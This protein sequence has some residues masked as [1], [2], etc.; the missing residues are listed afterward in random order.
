MNKRYLVSEQNILEINE[1]I[2]RILSKSF[3]L[4][5]NDGFSY[6]ITNTE[7]LTNKINIF[8]PKGCTAIEEDDFVSITD[9]EIVIVDNG[10]HHSKIVL[11][12]TDKK[13]IADLIQ[14]DIY[15]VVYFIE[16]LGYTEA[17]EALA[18]RI[19]TIIN[20][21]IP[22]VTFRRV[23]NNDQEETSE[24]EENRKDDTISAIKFGVDMSNNFKV[25]PNNPDDVYS[26]LYPTH[27]TKLKYLTEE[28]WKNIQLSAKKRIENVTDGVNKK[29]LYYW[30]NIV[31]GIIP[32]SLEVIND[33]FE[34]VADTSYSSEKEENRKDDAINTIEL[35]I[36]IK[37]KPNSLEDVYSLLYPDRQSKLEYLTEEEWKYLQDTAKDQIEN[38]SGPVCKKI[39]VHWYDIVNGEV[40]FGL[41]VINDNFDAVKPKAI[42]FE[43]EEGDKLIKDV[44]DNLAFVLSSLRSKL[45]LSLKHMG[46]W[47]KNDLLMKDTVE[48]YSKLLEN[49]SKLGGK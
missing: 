38:T 44:E 3:I 43:N 32:F 4:I 28:E 39:L 34:E 1:E 10:D 25:K 42:P 36:G 15:N 13:F 29:L 47:D 18:D 26:L 11:K 41:E 49:Y 23:K 8:G 20:P 14:V 12:H 40:P 27:T 30:C 2:E 24:K 35:N 22:P 48:L 33:S 5:E 9:N 17:S 45:L 46:E 21:V 37:P 31:D 7:F 19:D 16:A 6:H